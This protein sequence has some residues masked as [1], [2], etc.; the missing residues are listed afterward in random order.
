MDLFSQLRDQ[1][2]K[3]AR[4]ADGL[5]L[6]GWDELARVQTQ[7]LIRISEQL[8]QIISQLSDVKDGRRC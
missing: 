2:R 8:D 5:G 3:S 6:T 1:V 7:C 4:G